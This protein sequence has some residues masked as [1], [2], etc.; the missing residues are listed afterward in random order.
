MSSA[1]LSVVNILFPT[2]SRVSPA[3][4]ASLADVS[5]TLTCLLT[6]R[7]FLPLAPRCRIWFTSIWPLH[8]GMPLGFRGAGT[9]FGGGGFITG[10][11][12]RRRRLQAF[13]WKHWDKTMIMITVE[14][15]VELR[16][17]NSCRLVL[18]SFVWTLKNSLVLRL[19]L[20]ELSR[21]LKIGRLIW[22]HSFCCL[23]GTSYRRLSQSFLLSLTP[24]DKALAWCFV[25][26]L[27]LFLLK[28]LQ[29]KLPLLA[30]RRGMI[31]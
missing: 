23:F 30:W 5:N 8:R 26:S 3:N 10:D 25:N 2:H 6:L 1:P 15:N 22:K 28:R 31:E 19:N 12:R 11:L 7:F 9:N 21:V 17:F 13:A 18:L 29:V 14:R 4:L 20:E 24:P 16:I 27:L